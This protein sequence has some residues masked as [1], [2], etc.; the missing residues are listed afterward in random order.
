ML[1]PKVPANP[2]ARLAVADAGRVQ[3]RA[4]LAQTIAIQRASPE[5]YALKLGNA[6][7]A[8]RLIRDLRKNAGMVY[9]INPSIDAGQTRSL[10]RV[11][12]AC[13][14]QNVAKVH[15]SVTRELEEM[16]SAPVG[17]DELQRAKAMLLR[18]ISLAEASTDAIAQGL[19]ARWELDLPLDEPLLAARRYIDLSAEDIQ[20]A[21]A[22]WMRPADLVR[23]T[24]GP[25]S[26]LN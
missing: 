7:L 20:N 6:V 26:S 13:D 10:Y 18:Q 21:F 1:L 14:R 25:N 2:P 23:V 24:Q 9:A 17:A 22:R 8:A 4:V 12:Y 15:A 5:Y 3:D 11:E 19:I 16:R